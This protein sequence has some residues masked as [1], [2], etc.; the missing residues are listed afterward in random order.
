M[1][2]DRK[3]F[4]IFRNGYGR[5]YRWHDGE[6]IDKYGEKLFEST[7]AAH[8]AA[9]NYIDSMFNS[10]V[11]S[12]GKLPLVPHYFEIIDAE[13]HEILHKFDIKFKCAAEPA[14]VR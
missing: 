2:T 11:F 5:I 14:E 6:F 13:T 9:H 7:R 3:C 4:V 12:G 8:Q 10:V 1:D